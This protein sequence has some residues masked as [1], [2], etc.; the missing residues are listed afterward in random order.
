METVHFIVQRKELRHD[1]SVQVAE[2][3]LSKSKTLNSKHSTM[4]NE[5]RGG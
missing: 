2:C 1:S 3:L 5:R 4:K